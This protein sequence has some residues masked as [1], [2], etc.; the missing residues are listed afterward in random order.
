MPTSIREQILVAFKA[1]L[2]TLTGVAV[3]RMRRKAI[4]KADFPAVNQLDGLDRVTEEV[5]GYDK[6]EMSVAVEGF[7]AGATDEAMASA[8]SDLEAQV[9]AALLGGDRKLGGLAVDITEGEGDF[10]ADEGDGK[11]PEA[12]FSRIFV[13]TFFTGA[14]DPFAAGP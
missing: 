12:V 10:D 1:R 3:Y 11:S 13:V 9:V 8:A 7:V 4:A 2:A 6:R 5:F 14:G